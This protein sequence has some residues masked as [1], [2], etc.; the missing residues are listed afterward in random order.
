MPVYNAQEYLGEAIDCILAQTYEDWELICVDDGS[1]DASLTILHSYA[2]RYA[3]VRVISRPNTGIVGALNDALEAA[4]GE[5]IARM[6][7][8]DWCAESRFQRQV[9]YMDEHHE[10]V[11]VGSW[12]QRTDPFGSPA[13]SQEPPTD[14]ETI[15]AGLLAGDA[16]VLVHASLMMRAD[17]L[18]AV[19]G[20]REGTDW[21]EDLDLFLRLT[22]FGRVANLPAYL[23]V[24]RRHA[25]SVCFKRYELMCRRLKDVLREAYERRGITDRY[26][27]SAVRPDLAP[28]Q[29]AAEHYRIWACHA[30]HAGNRTLAC[31]HAYEALKRAPLSPRTWK[32]AYWALAA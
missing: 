31:K 13:G 18:R 12:V 8:D 25:Q 21:V 20:W 17:A 27:E 2:D 9:E 29:S 3:K 26:D 10:C 6:D 32:V 7:A 24:Y 30:I 11:A 28:R 16:S 4:R 23:Y 1:R 19:G 15:D 5:Y 22:E 14:H